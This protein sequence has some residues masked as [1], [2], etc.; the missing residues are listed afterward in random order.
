MSEPRTPRVAVGAVVLAGDAAAPSV[1]L[2]KRRNPPL[3]GAWSL[4]GGRVEV[5]EAL[6]A[7]VQR[8]VGEETGLVV[9]VGELV[10]VVEIID[11]AHHYVILDYLCEIE[12]GA[13]RPG[14]DAL[15][16]A[17]VEVGA[18]TARQV[19]TAVHQV[20]ARAR[21]LAARRAGAGS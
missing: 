21:V 3:P 18:L 9:R 20:V 1:L 4:P 16:A 15:E 6:H 2:V 19:T 11:E 5:G 8:E 10:E 17:F 12:G 7:A 14:D 13:L